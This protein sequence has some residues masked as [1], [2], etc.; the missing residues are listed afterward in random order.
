[1]DI[2]ELYLRTSRDTIS[3]VGNIYMK[4]RA[5][6]MYYGERKAIIF[7]YQQRKQK[8]NIKII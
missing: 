6:W 2:I 8:R 3:F 7:Q 4:L 5:D 1:M